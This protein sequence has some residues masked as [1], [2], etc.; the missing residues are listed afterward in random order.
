MTPSSSKHNHTSPVHN[1]SVI[2]A[3]FGAG[4]D[5]YIH[6]LGVQPNASGSQIQTAF[7]H[8]RR[9]LLEQ[10]ENANSTLVRQRLER[11]ID[12]VVLAVR[13]LGEW[14]NEYDDIRSERVLVY[15]GNKSSSSPPPS[16]VDTSNSDQ[17][18]EQ[19]EDCADI[20]MKRKSRKKTSRGKGNSSNRRL[21][22]ST[23]AAL[24]TSMDSTLTS[25]TGAGSRFSIQSAPFTAAKL[26]YSARQQHHHRSNDR[27]YQQ[28]QHKPAVVTPEHG[29][30]SKR[31]HPATS[32]H[33]SKHSARRR[34]NYDD[35][36]EEEEVE[37][38][39]PNENTDDG[40]LQEDETIVSEGTFKERQGLLDRFRDE[41]IGALEDTSSA[42]E[43]VFNVFTL[44][45][46]DIAAVTGKI[47]K[48][49]RQMKKAI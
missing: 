22:A 31:L 25:S 5:L 33:R 38:L 4:A 11:Q 48:A 45:E 46:E 20:P 6:V 15:K 37:T 10:L 18:H 35:D 28:Q 49:K 7:L 30:R 41:I 42:V 27:G 24:N 43:Q 32:S 34:K 29:D 16:F 40:T 9:D 26:P 17:S 2:D 36:D 1:L 47:H 39:P 23:D 21:N 8:R 44:Q 3:A 19:Q 14:R 13:I 12:A